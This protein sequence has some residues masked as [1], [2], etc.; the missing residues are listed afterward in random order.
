MLL[1]SNLLSYMFTY[2]H[3]LIK[4]ENKDKAVIS[5]KTKLI[6]SEGLDEGLEKSRL[7]LKFE[8]FSVPTFSFYFKKKKGVATV[9]HWFK[10][11][12]AAAGV[13]AEAQTRSQPGA[14][15]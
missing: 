14:V 7:T 12:T 1:A 9:V 4:C 5:K 3:K 11:P 6:L 8:S 2:I 15:G 10:K 13:S